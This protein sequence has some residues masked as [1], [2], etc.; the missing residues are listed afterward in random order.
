MCSDAKEPPPYAK[1]SD[2]NYTRYARYADLD[3]LITVFGQIKADNPARMIR[4]LPTDRLVQ[5]FALN[6]VILIGG[7]ASDAAR[8]FAQDLPPYRLRRRFRA[9]NRGRTSSIAA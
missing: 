3:A 1:A 4:I 9:R 8:L 6:H 2:L 5:D 7:A